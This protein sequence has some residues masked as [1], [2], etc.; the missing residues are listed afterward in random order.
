MVAAIWQ[1]LDKELRL[2]C[3]PF[4]HLQDGDPG[5]LLNALF[6]LGEQLAHY[7]K[8]KIAQM[9]ALVL[10]RLLYLQK[11][12]LDIFKEICSRAKDYFADVVV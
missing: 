4:D 5:K 8:P 12:Q 6:D 7:G 2:S 11:E 3:E 1:L 9:V 10:S